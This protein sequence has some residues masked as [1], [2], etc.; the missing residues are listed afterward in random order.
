M[1]RGFVLVAVLWILVAVTTL[2]AASIVVTRGAV[3]ASRNRV[4]ASRARWLAE[5]CAATVR[6]IV[7]TE[8]ATD[9]STGVRI[10]RWRTLDDVVRERL[11]VSPL[12]CDV[13]LSP[14]GARL[15]VNMA[16]AAQL[17]RVLGALGASGS[18]L[19]SLTV[20][21][22]AWRGRLSDATQ[23]WRDPYLAAAR[24]T[25]PRLD[26][27]FSGEMGRV[28]LDRAAPEVLAALPAFGAEA[29]ARTLE[30]RA[31]GLHTD[32]STLAGSLSTAA[33]DSMLVHSTELS[34]LTTSEPDAWILEARAR[35]GWPPVATTVE[36]RLVRGAGRG[37]VVRR[38]SWP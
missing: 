26:S 31:R 16:D 14:V 8:L 13:Q 3:A 27:V 2:T 36:L 11:S 37:A 15:D 17:R 20:A 10:P 6:A 7:A 22:L 30:R 1:R 38:R 4:S 12:P 34:R 5:G 28:V 24:E 9:D 23:L 33:R 35:A 19:D 25:T 21:V 18:Y 32:V 29:I